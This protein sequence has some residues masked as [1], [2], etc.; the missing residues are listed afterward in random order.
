M[1]YSLGIFSW[2]FSIRLSLTRI[3][4]NAIFGIYASRVFHIRMARA[5]QITAQT[6]VLQVPD[7]D[8][9]GVV[10]TLTTEHCLPHFKS[11]EKQTFI[12]KYLRTVFGTIGAGLAAW[13][14]TADQL[15]FLAT[16]VSRVDVNRIVYNFIFYT[17]ELSRRHFGHALWRTRFSRDHCA[18]GIDLMQRLKDLETLWSEDTICSYS[19][20]EKNASVGAVDLS[21]NSTGMTAP[22]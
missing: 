11:Q 10:I 18:N 9:Y 3:V 17:N 1:D 6:P 21:E 7:S 15:T 22:L 14:L 5:T 4:G 2:N 12:L 16:G 20:L 19:I 8:D 13:Y